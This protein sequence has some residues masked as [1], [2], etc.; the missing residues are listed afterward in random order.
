MGGLR[1]DGT[2]SAAVVRIDPGTGRA[3]RWAALA[4]PSHDAAGAVLGGVP[5]LF[6]GG[7]AASSAAVQRLAVGEVRR[8]G[9]LPGPRS[10]LT[11]V[12]VGR[13]AYLLGGYDGT[14]WQAAVLRTSDGIRFATVATLPEPVRYAAAAYFGGSI[15]LFGGRSTSGP[16]AVV[17]RID[18]GRGTAAVAGRLPQPLTDATAVTLGGAIY[19]CGGRVNGVVTGQVLR[20]DPATGRFTAAGR[21]PSPVA[22]A[23]GVV[24]GDVAYL[25]GGESPTVAGTVTTLRMEAG[26][27]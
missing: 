9:S 10:D 17:Q 13:E 8:A 24:L 26:A 16:T 25:L 22:D 23:A 15:W 14:R 1:A 4:L 12:T 21:L 19:L 27:R 6:G 3:S 2:S 18:A 5:L 7:T 11:A 20:F